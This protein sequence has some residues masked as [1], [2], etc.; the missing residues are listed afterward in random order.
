MR[1]THA[2]HALI[3]VEARNAL[4]LLIGRAHYFCGGPELGD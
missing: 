3:D 2:H 1:T 4:S